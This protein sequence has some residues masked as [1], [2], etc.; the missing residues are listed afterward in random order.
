MQILSWMLPDHL[1]TKALQ[2]GIL[3][4][5]KVNCNSLKFLVSLLD[6]NVNLA[7]MQKFFTKEVWVKETDLMTKL[8]KHLK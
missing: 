7:S 2:S 4:Y 5:D 6:E 1:V 8:E 3:E